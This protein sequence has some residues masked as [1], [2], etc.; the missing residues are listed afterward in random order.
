MGDV[1]WPDPPQWEVQEE[2]MAWRRHRERQRGPYK[3]AKPPLS[4]ADHQLA[5]RVMVH[6]GW[7]YDEARKRLELSGM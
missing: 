2:I 1:L 5:L 6:H 7:S 3:H 4:D